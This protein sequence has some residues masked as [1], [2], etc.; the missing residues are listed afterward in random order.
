MQ[1]MNGVALGP[2]IVWAQQQRELKQTLRRLIKE[3]EDHA[4][5]NARRG[6]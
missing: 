6:F 2:Y 3:K 1:F 5:A 4:R